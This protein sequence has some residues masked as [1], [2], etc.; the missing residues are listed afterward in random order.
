MNYLTSWL[1]NSS[2]PVSGNLVAIFDPA[3]AP[4]L[5]PRCP[6]TLKPLSGAGFFYCVHNTHYFPA[7]RSGGYPYRGHPPKK[8]IIID[9]QRGV[10]PLTL[11]PQVA[12]VQRLPQM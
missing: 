6:D 5:L 3:P 1:N 8:R 9:S 12:E 11:H 7:K 10:N 2:R 4:A